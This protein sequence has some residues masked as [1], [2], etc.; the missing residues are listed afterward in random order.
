MRGFDLAGSITKERLVLRA[1]EPEDADVVF[2]MQSDE[3]L[4]RFVEWGPR[5]REEV[6][7]SVAKKIAATAIHD[8]GDVLSLAVTL[9]DTGALVGDV[10]LQYPSAGIAGE[11][12]ASWCT[13][14]TPAAGRRPK[15]HASCCGSRSTTSRCT[16]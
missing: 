14:S 12:S 9:G 8:K 1:F 7:E 5:T 3:D 16:G 15:P 11:R 6:A 4:L 2:E 10:V 13:R